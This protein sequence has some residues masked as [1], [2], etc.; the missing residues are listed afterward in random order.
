LIDAAVERARQR[1]VGVLAATG[2]QSEAQ[3][4]FAGS[5]SCLNRVVQIAA[6]MLQ[7]H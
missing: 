4:P 3:L 7:R 2:V 5:T 1:S 6:E